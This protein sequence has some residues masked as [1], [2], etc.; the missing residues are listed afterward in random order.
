M[1]LYFDA[2]LD[3]PIQPFECIPID[4]RDFIGRDS[5]HRSIF[6][7]NV[8]NILMPTPPPIPHIL[9]HMRD[10]GSKRPGNMC[11]GMKVNTISPCREDGDDERDPDEFGNLKSRVLFQTNMQLNKV[12]DLGQHGGCYRSGSGP[13]VGLNTLSLADMPRAPPRKLTAEMRSGGEIQV[14]P[15]SLDWRENE[16][17]GHRTLAKM[18]D[19]ANEFNIVYLRSSPPA[20]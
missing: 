2:G 8:E 5:H 4:K 9:P 7:V 13:R 16:S 1:K 12:V 17:F 19:T 10:F 3:M 11:E 15:P 18:Y 14:S 6:L 20:K